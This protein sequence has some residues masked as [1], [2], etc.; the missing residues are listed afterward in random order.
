MSDLIITKKKL[1]TPLNEIDLVISIFNQ[2]NIIELILKQLFENT[3]TPFNLIL[4]FDGCT[5]KTEEVALKYITQHKPVN[6]KKTITTKTNN[7]YETKANNIGLR[8]A[9]SEYVISLQ[10]DMAILER[11]WEIRLTYP[12]RAYEKILAVTA[13]MA[14]NID[15]Q[16]NNNF[17]Y[18]N[19]AARELLTL[20]RNTFSIRDVINRG[21][22]AFHLENLKKMNYFNED[23]APSDLDDADLC[24]RAWRKH[25]LCCGSFWIDY[26]SRPE[27]SKSKSKDSTM[28]NHTSQ[29][30]N[31]KI[32][33]NNHG[34]YIQKGVKHDKDITI[35][36]KEID[37][38]K[39]FL[40]RKHT[41]K[42]VKSQFFY[43]FPAIYRM[44]VRKLHA[45]ISK[46]KTYIGTAIY[47][48]SESK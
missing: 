27:W 2:E 22:I 42:I 6:L 7:V 11:G 12:I 17:I 37:Y 20:G 47:V 14:L 21:P 4:V 29:L 33:V 3:I 48:S 23:F 1:T 10:D 19:K 18:K 36:E 16:K 43:Q 13:R 45:F 34:S 40:S 39:D 15:S 28:N 32:I 31:V 8:L 41:L 30:K 35:L 24:L 5:D 9:T 46:T 44:S 26:I 38:P 25:K